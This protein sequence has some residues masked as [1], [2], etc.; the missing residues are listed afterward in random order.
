MAALARTSED[1]ALQAALD[2]TF[3][4]VRGGGNPPRE[5]LVEFEALLE[6]SGSA[7][8]QEA[9]RR[10]GEPPPEVIDEVRA[11]LKTIGA[12]SLEALFEAAYESAGE[13]FDAFLQAMLTARAEALQ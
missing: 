6:A 7:E 5:M 4:A 10:L 13:E 2:K 9:Y 11:K 12:P 8:L 3:E 1:L